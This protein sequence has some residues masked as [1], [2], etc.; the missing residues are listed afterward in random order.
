MRQG[1]EK[2]L[3]SLDV[4]T[5]SQFLVDAQERWVQE[6][7]KN[8]WQKSDGRPVVNREE[9]QSLNQ[10]IR[11]SGMDVR[12]LHIPAHAGNWG[13]EQADKLARQGANQQ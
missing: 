1:A 6:W 12:F 7:E 3:S 5:D 4:Y 13:N 8:G 10:N 11:D 2:G 9:L